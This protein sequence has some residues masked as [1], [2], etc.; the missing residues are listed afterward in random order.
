M[1]VLW[2]FQNTWTICHLH[3]ES[4]GGVMGYNVEE[5]RQCPKCGS[6]ETK[7][8]YNRYIKKQDKYIRERKCKDCGE[9][10]RT[11]EVIIK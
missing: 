4:D 8:L 5:G 11:K 1:M 7:V 6:F 3:R 9:K 10:W 2:K